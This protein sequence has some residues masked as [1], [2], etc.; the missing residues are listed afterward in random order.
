MNILIVGLKRLLANIIRI[1]IVSDVDHA[2]GM[3]RVKIGNL[4]TDW[5]NW[6]T[7]RAGRVCFWSAP[8]VGEQVMVLSIGGELTTGFVLPANAED[9]NIRAMASIADGA[10]LEKQHK[11]LTLN[12]IL[13][14]HSM[15]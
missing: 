8:S 6:L 1:G 2:N 14:S 9:H 10:K 4:E 12:W 13:I 11:R 7:L 3:C 15:I 5:L